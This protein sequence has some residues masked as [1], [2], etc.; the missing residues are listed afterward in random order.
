[1]QA[2]TKM[3][4][5]VYTCALTDRAGC[6]S[7]VRAQ[8]LPFT[9]ACDM[10]AALENAAK[11]V[12]PCATSSGRGLKVWGAAMLDGTPDMSVDTIKDIC[13]TASV[14][15]KAGLLSPK[16]EKAS[17]LDLEA[18]VWAATAGIARSALS[19]VVTRFTEQPSA[20][21]VADDR[22]GWVFDEIF[23]KTGKAECQGYFGNTT[24]DE[25]GKL[26]SDKAVRDWAF[27]KAVQDRSTEC[28]QCAADMVALCEK[29][30]NNLSKEFQEIM[31]T[32]NLLSSLLINIEAL[33]AAGSIYEAGGKVATENTLDS[34]WNTFQFLKSQL[35]VSST[36]TPPSGMRTPSMH[37]GILDC[38]ASRGQ[39]PT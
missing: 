4:T 35:P 21:W 3:L 28:T 2:I 25:L 20:A 27:D 8:Q 34:L 9:K 16:F 36:P 23:G 37:D 22:I 32:T 12:P 26:A 15:V 10:T 13:S 11:Q 31:D 38:T 1:M 39:H 29:V 24:C 6:I 30:A 33:Y 5:I 7:M 14:M 19:L 17:H 18:K